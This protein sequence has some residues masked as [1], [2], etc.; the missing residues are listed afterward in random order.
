MLLVFV[1]TSPFVQVVEAGPVGPTEP[2]SID[3]YD[4]NGF[5]EN[6]WDS[7]CRANLEQCEHGRAGNVTTGETWCA[8]GGGGPPPPPPPPNI[9]SLNVGAQCIGGTA[10][11]VRAGGEGTSQQIRRSPGGLVVG[12]PFTFNDMQEGVEYRFDVKAEGP[13]GGSG[14]GNLSPIV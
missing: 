14:W 10:R 11:T 1:M 8:Q 12:N 13:G 3:W 7:D 4:E 5:V 9:P 6:R 2:C